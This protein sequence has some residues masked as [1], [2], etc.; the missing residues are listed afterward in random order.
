MT[1][2][3]LQTELRMASQGEPGLIENSINSHTDGGDDADADHHHDDVVDHLDVIDSQ[4]GAF[5]NLT[6]AANSIVIPPSS[7]Y[8]RKPVAVLPSLPRKTDD[9]ENSEEFDDI[10]DRHVD[11]VLKRPSKIRRT[12]MGVWSFLK[13]R[14]PINCLNQRSSY[15]LVFWGAAIVIFLAKIINFHNAN[16]QGFWIEV[17]SQ[18]ETGLFTLTSIGLIPSRALDT[19]RIYKIWTY[20]RRTTKLRKKAGLPELFDVDDLPDPVYDPNYVHVLTEEEQAD[21]HRQQRKLQYSQTWYRAHGTETHRAFPINMAL[22]ICFLNDGNSFFQASA[23][24]SIVMLQIFLCGTMWGLN[25]FERPPW[26]T[27]LLIPASFICGIAAAVVIW[28]GGER[29][30]RVDEVKDRLRAAL[31]N[32][33][34]PEDDQ[35]PQSLSR[36]P[37]P[38]TNSTSAMLV[39]ESREKD[40]DHASA[41]SIIEES[42][43]VPR[44]SKFDEL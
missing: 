27:G 8:S 23:L 42:M 33:P 11:D 5:S 32:K 22:L 44:A 39:D 4:I 6:N 28:K 16:T 10:L 37:R 9:S 14:N 21:L 43:T 31:A 18:V 7:W 25:R 3:G 24:M 13:T 2:E 30:K 36:N 38:G 19:Y 20:K 1:I 12:L 29:T 41:S 17:S 40:R 15:L 35:L 26:T 34:P